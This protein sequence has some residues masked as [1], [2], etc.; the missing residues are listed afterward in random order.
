MPPERADRRP[1]LDV[2]ELQVIAGEIGPERFR[3]GQFEAA[4]RLFGNMIRNPEF[5]DFLT[6][7]AYERLA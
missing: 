2:P 3:K 5:D 4:T 7:P 6:L 1:V